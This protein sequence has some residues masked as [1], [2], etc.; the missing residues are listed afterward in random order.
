MNSWEQHV[1]AKSRQLRFSQRQMVESLVAVLAA[2][3]DCPKN[4]E[5]L[6]EPTPFSADSALADQPSHSNYSIV[7]RAEHTLS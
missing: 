1:R 5:D 2:D 3:G 4:F 7:R 6:T